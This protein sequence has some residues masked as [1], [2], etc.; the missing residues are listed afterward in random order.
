VNLS[1]L[2]GGTS[3]RR[4]KTSTCSRGLRQA[5][6]A[7]PWRRSIR[8]STELRPQQRA[9]PK[10]SDKFIYPATTHQAPTALE[11]KIDWLPAVAEDL[12]LR[13]GRHSALRS[14]PRSTH[15]IASPS[16]TTYSITGI[17]RTS[18]SSCSEK[19]TRNR[20]QVQLLHSI[21]DRREDLDTAGH[22]IVQFSAPHV[23]STP[24]DLLSSPADRRSPVTRGGIEAKLLPRHPDIRRRCLRRSRT[25]ALSAGV[26]FPFDGPPVRVRFGL[27]SRTTPFILTIDLFGGGGFFSLEDRAGRHRA[28][29]VSLEFRR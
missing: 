18:S 17:S 16:Q 24:E 15:P 22:R 21:R 25:S 26:T 4:S 1:D 23:L 13:A 7:I 11:V 6:G 14:T 19:P 8:R 29:E 28:D 5:P 12:A 10:I 20:D 9:S 3:T 27:S 2:V